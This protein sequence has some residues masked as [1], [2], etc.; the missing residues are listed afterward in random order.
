MANIVIPQQGDPIAPTFTAHAALLTQWRRT[1]DADRLPILPPETRSKIEA[2]IRSYISDRAPEKACFAMAAKLR[3]AYPQ[4]VRDPGATTIW[5]GVVA[6]ALA[7]FPSRVGAEA[8]RKLSRDI[9][10]P[11]AASEVRTACQAELDPHYGALADLKRMERQEKQRTEA[12]AARQRTALIHR[13][14]VT[15]GWRSPDLEFDPPELVAEHERVKNSPEAAHFPE[16]A[17]EFYTSRG[18]PC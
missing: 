18:C 16:W 1:E 14:K 13:Q 10:F 7:E 6:E 8:V 12:K 9:P 2:E 11:P 15:A 5:L 17:K 4:P 3:A